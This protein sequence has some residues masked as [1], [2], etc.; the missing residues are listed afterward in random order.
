[1]KTHQALTT[2]ERGYGHDH[3]KRRAEWAPKVDRGEVDCTRCGKPIA[4][5]GAR[6]P[7]CGKRSCRWDLGHDDF[8]RSLYNGPEHSCCNRA[9]SGRRKRRR[10]PRYQSRVWY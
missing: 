4:P 1:M 7:K 10:W 9:T 3:V 5:K 6:C 8:D 2:K